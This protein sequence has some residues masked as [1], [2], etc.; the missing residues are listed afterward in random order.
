LKIE[1]WQAVVRAIEAAFPE[2]DDV[3]EKISFG[4]AQ[5]ARI[6]LAGHLDLKEGMFVLDAGIGPGTMSEVL[7]LKSADITIIGLDAS[8]K[9]LSAAG[10]R[11]L[12]PFCNRVHLVRGIFEALPFKDQ[13][14]QRIVSA[15]ALRDAQDRN[16]AIDEFHR[17]SSNEGI[18]GMVDLG[19]PG[20][21]LK[22][23]LISFYVHY[24][25]PTIARFSMSGGIVGNPWRMIFPTYQ[26]LESNN[27]LL[28]FLKNRFDH[29][30]TTEMSLGGVIIAIAHK[31]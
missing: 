4:R 19:K 2:Y 23:I 27:E 25:V 18:F 16:S 28:A 29:V 3:N 9:L 30:E 21:P 8:T 24:I 26:A 6:R 13:C 20:N 11:L 12:E 7:L 17:V 10:K 1:L 15:Y 14:F 31:R 5:Q 22:R